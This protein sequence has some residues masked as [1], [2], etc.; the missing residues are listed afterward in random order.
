MPWRYRL[1]GTRP[2]LIGGYRS[3]DRT[4]MIITMRRL[5]TSTLVA[6]GLLI[7]PTAPCDSRDAAAQDTD[8]RVPHDM[9]ITPA[10]RPKIAVSPPAKDRVEVPEKYRG[11]HV[12]HDKEGKKWGIDFT[13]A[14][15]AGY[16]A[17][18]QDFL[19]SFQ[20]GSLDLEEVEGDKVAKH[21]VLR[22]TIGGEPF[23]PG[24]LAGAAACRDALV[25]LAK[26]RKLVYLPALPK[27]VKRLRVLGAC[28]PRLNDAGRPTC[29]WW[30]YTTVGMKLSDEDL[31]V[32]QDIPLSDLEELGLDHVSVSDVG[33]A[34]LPP[35]P[36]LKRLDMSSKNLTGAC[37]HWLRRFPQLETL[38]LPGLKGV[39]TEDFAAVGQLKRLEFLNLQ[40][41]ELDDNAVPVL[42]S[43]P[44]LS[45]LILERSY[46]GS[47]G[48]RFSADGI[49]R[50]R[51]CRTLKC[52]R[53]TGCAVDDTALT[54][55]TS[56]LSELDDLFVGK[57]RITDSSM[58]AIQNL[59]HL[60]W[61]DIAETK[62]SDA[63][64]TAIGPHPSIKTIS[65]EGTRVGNPSLAALATMPKLKEVWSSP[66]Q[67]SGAALSEFEKRRPDVQIHVV[68]RTAGRGGQ[69]PN[70]SIGP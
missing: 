3:C 29:I 43:L 35:M 60:A 38:E 42:L 46:N 24:Q 49:A 70:D 14:Y 57:T 26:T 12:V 1:G 31:K 22:Q 53:L 10:A 64:I 68:E 66:D 50:F 44:R 40:A 39:K 67:F 21:L 27:W 32:F 59:R 62:V 45:V 58:K 48:P 11:V 30:N 61:L 4:E 37:L 47:C 65:L 2:S 8:A 63:G 16:V 69:I 17:G 19:A 28:E 6:L 34:G 55:I 36:K 9:D 54:A 5:T 33:I 15:R 18:W 52:L 13:A 7:V 51:A 25:A 23:Y 20:G 41:V 56:S